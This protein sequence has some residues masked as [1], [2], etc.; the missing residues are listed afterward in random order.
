MRSLNKVILD[1]KHDLPLSRLL[2][3]IKLTPKVRMYMQTEKKG[4]LR[5]FKEASKKEYTSGAWVA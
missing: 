4:L 3:K 2:S 1:A 5:L